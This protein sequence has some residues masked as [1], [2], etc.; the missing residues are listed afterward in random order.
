M[1]ANDI[2]LQKEEGE[3]L[4]NILLN[5]VHNGD[6]NEMYKYFCSKVEHIKAYGKDDKGN[7]IETQMINYCSFRRDSVISMYK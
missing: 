3:L 4:Y 7:D 6:V 5:K 1:A 2:E